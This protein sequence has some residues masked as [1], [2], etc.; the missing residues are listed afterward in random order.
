MQAELHDLLKPVSDHIQEIQNF[1]E[2]NRGS[3]FFNHLSAIS[4]SIPALGWVAVVRKD[5]ITHWLA[6]R[7]TNVYR[8]TH[9]F[10]VQRTEIDFKTSV[11]TDDT[12]LLSKFK[13][14]LQILCVFFFCEVTFV[15]FCKFSIFD[16]ATKTSSKRHN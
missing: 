8:K 1:R 12:K 14:P 2:R 5:R 13:Q 4:E 3:S 15:L 10:H 9:I 11:F 16:L 6:S 7:H